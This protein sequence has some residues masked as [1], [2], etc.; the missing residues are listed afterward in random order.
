MISIEEMHLNAKL[1]PVVSTLF[2]ENA[3]LVIESTVF[4]ASFDF[5]I[6]SF[7]AWFKIIN[8]LQFYIQRI[9]TN[10]IC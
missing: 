1:A 8:I 10:L 6:K 7:V 3:E 4:V 2:A 5:S 9:I